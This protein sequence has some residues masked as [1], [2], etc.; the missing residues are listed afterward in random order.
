M[1]KNVPKY[2]PDWVPTVEY[3]AET[4]KRDVRYAWCNDRRTLLWFA[5]QRAIEY[6]PAL[7]RTE[8]PDRVTHLVLDLD[9]PDVG[10]FD[11]AVRVAHLVRRALAEVDLEGAVKTSG[12]KG[13]HIFVPIDTDATMEDAAAATRAI[14]ARTERLDPE[15]ATTAFMKEDRGGKVFVDSTRSGGATVI[16]A[17]SPRVPAGVPVSYPVSWDDLTR[18]ALGDASRSTPAT[19]T[20]RERPMAGR[21]LASSARRARRRGPRHSGRPG[22]GDARGQAASRAR[23]TTVCGGQP[24]RWGCETGGRVTRTYSMIDFERDRGGSSGEPLRRPRAS[25]RP[26]DVGDI[27]HA[28]RVKIRSCTRIC[29]AL[30]PARRAGRGGQPDPL[31][32]PRGDPARPNAAVAVRRRPRQRDARARSAAARLPNRHRRPPSWTCTICRTTQQ[33][34]HAGRFD[35]E[36]C[37][38]AQPA[39]EACNEIR[40][41]RE[42]KTNWRCGAAATTGHRRRVARGTS[43]ARAAK[44]ARLS[45]PTSIIIAPASSR[46]GYARLR[47]QGQY[48]P[49]SPGSGGRAVRGAIVSEPAAARAGRHPQVLVMVVAIRL[50]MSASPLA[51]MALSV[52]KIELEMS[53]SPR[54]L[55]RGSERRVDWPTSPKSCTGTST[56]TSA[57]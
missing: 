23:R 35:C 6:H 4:S 31:H 43:S 22:G 20:R 55:L 29:I 28:R 12:A 56:S 52:R 45:A 11:V 24:G 10:A 36:N 8:H 50:V 13:V 26:A 46:L 18:V 32:Q 40:S 41:R 25:S 48:S 17:Y 2:T 47:G 42:R 1:Q 34:P 53:I 54:R 14:A 33:V 16:A 51:G 27:R 15:I 39:R 5:N 9:P 19:C 30:L 44:P 38:V 7:V 37:Q 3:W 49:S 57:R 21:C